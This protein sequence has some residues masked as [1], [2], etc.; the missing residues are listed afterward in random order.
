MRPPQRC[1]CLTGGPDDRL[2]WCQRVL[3]S[4]RPLPE[5]RRHNAGRGMSAGHAIGS[6]QLSERKRIARSSLRVVIAPPRRNRAMVSPLPVAW[7]DTVDTLRPVCL[8]NKSK[9]AT[10]RLAVS[11]TTRQRVTSTGLWQVVFSESVSCSSRHSTEETGAATD[12]VSRD[13]PVRF[14]LFKRLS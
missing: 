14:R 13:P 1:S 8:A 5:V 9:S 7:R 6:G 2:R 12:H 11:S 3:G 10:N 4:V